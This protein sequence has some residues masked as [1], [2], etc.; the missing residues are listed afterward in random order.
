[1]ALAGMQSACTPTSE[2]P[3]H[4]ASLASPTAPQLSGAIITPVGLLF[5][6]YSLYQYRRR[7]YQVGHMHL[8]RMHASGRRGAATATS[9]HGQLDRHTDDATVH[10]AFA[11]LPVAAR[12]A[13]IPRLACPP[14]QCRSCGAR[15]HA[16]VSRSAQQQET[17]LASLPQHGWRRSHACRSNR[18]CYAGAVAWQR[19]PSLNAPKLVQLVCSCSRSSSTCLPRSAD[20]QRGTTLLTVILAAVFLLTFVLA[21]VYMF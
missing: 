3:H 11:L 17:W 10:V 13:T 8:P 19:K 12:S 2:Q 7:T 15:Q 6:V 14:P 1:M 16:T 18:V 9:E 4:P 5:M 21:L 20:D